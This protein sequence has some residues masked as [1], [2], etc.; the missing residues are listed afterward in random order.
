[1]LE[2]LRQAKVWPESSLPT[3]CVTD[4]L[5]E[6]VVGP[7][8]VL[9]SPDTADMQTVKE[10]VQES[11]MLRLL[12]EPHS[13]GTVEGADTVQGVDQDQSASKVHKSEG[14]ARLTANEK[15]QLLLHK[16]GKHTKS[17]YELLLHVALNRRKAAT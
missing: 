13:N 10:L 11:E 9:V 3:D 15:K 2:R 1:M 16:A 12:S 6:M 17:R 7:M 14:F 5:P 4:T 8:P